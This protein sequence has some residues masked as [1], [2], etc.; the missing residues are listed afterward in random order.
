MTWL[1]QNTY[2]HVLPTLNPDGFHKSDE[3][4]CEG[5]EGRGNARNMDLNRNFPDLY[6]QNKLM[7]QP[8][9]LAVKKWMSDVPFIL[10]ASLHGGALVANYPYDTVKE[11][12]E[13]SIMVNLR[14]PQ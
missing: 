11:M 14:M 5:E 10:S 3:G 2:I 8:E 7:P 1:L 6:V 12:S 4:R 13:Y 9:M